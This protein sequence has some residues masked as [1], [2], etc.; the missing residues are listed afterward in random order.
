MNN[1]VSGFYPILDPSLAPDHDAYY[2][3]EALL[4]SGALVLQL[5]QKAMNEASFLD[6]AMQISYL[7]IHNRF[8]LIINSF[9]EVAQ[10][11]EADGL[12]LPSQSKISISEARQ[13]LGT[14]ALIG[15]S[16]HSLEE[17][18]RKIEEGADY[19]IFGSIYPSAGKP[20]GHPVQGVKKLAELTQKSSVPIIA[21]GGI[22]LN[23]I[24]EVKSAGASGFS[25]LKA[26]YYNEKPHAAVKALS[27]SW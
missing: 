21:I 14:N 27:E 6:L 1:S 10:K 2:L 26:V 25:S 17:A 15:A 12:H 20:E 23:R 24:A 18:K 8:K 16:V 9:M 4:S 11:V 3:A 22:S 19:L 7:R 5:R 13:K